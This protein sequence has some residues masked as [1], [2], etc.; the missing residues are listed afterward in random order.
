MESRHYVS[1]D[2]FIQELNLEVIYA[3]EGYE[4]IQ[5]RTE[6]VNRPGLQLAGFF[7]YFVPQRIQLI[8]LVETTYLTN[9]TA[10]YR[11]TSFEKLFTYD[12]PA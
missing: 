7:D 9:L 11:R 12:V 2:K 8:G 5:I 1:L 4:N 10:D 3:P 6:D